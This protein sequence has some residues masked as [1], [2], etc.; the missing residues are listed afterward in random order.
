MAAVDLKRFAAYLPA[1]NIKVRPVCELDANVPQAGWISIQI[2]S[3]KS[4]TTP[5]GCGF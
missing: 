1:A 3:D 2:S 4:K 5:Q